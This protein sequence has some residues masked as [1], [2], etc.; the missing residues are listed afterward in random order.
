M[1]FRNSSGRAG[2]FPAIFACNWTSL[3]DDST[4]V[5]PVADPDKSLLRKLAT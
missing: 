4:Q 2:L 3:K 5:L 1:A